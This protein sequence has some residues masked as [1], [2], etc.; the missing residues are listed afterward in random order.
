MAVAILLHGYEN[1]NVMKQQG[2]RT[3]TAQIKILG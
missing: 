3:E 2:Q 1:L